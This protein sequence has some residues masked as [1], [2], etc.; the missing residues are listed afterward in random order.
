MCEITF[1]HRTISGENN[2]LIGYYYYYP[3]KMSELSEKSIQANKQKL[4]RRTVEKWIVEND[5]TLS[6][7]HC[8]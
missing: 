1:G 4:S 7:Q 8:G 6:T 3:E 5:K 2:H